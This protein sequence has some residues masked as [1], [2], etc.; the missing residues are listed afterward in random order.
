MIILRG[1]PPQKAP[2]LADALYAGGVRLLEVTFDQRTDGED[3]C[4][5]LAGLSQRFG[6]KLRIG[7]GTVM[8]PRQVDMAAE[9]GASFIVAPNV[10][11]AVISHALA[12]GLLPIPGGLTPTEIAL[13]YSFG[14]PLVKLFPAAALGPGYAQALRDPLPHIPLLA[15]GG[16]DEHNAAAFLRAGLWAVGVGGRVTR[17]AAEGDYAG[18]EAL[19]KKFVE[20]VAV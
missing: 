20:A 2:P 10:D 13:A 7:A 17:A 18:V 16:I 1:I 8:T 15:V 3:T 12:R 19:A 4:A 9:A 14:A 6:E 5:I 11:R